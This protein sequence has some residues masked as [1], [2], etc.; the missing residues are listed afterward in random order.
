MKKKYVSCLV[1][2]V[3]V[4]IGIVMALPLGALAQKKNMSRTEDFIVVSGQELS[5]LF[6]AKIESLHL[7]QCL[8][9]SCRPMP[10]QVDKV[11]VLGR[12]VFP[13]DKNANRD[14]AALDDNDE[15]SFMVEDAGDRIPDG[16]RPPG[17]KRGVE[18]EISD[19]LDGGKAWAYLFEENGPQDSGL[20]DYVSYHT[21]GDLTVIESDQM[22]LGF[23][24]GGVSYTLL[25]MISPSGELG[26]SVLDRQRMGAE[27]VWLG[28]VN[29]SMSAPESIMET[30]DIGVIDGPVRV[31]VDEIVLVKMGELSFQWGTEYFFKVYRCG[32][33]N[34]VVY[35]FP[36]AVNALFQSTLLYWGLDF[37]PDMI[38]SSYLD[39]NH[40]QPVLITDTAISDFGGTDENYWYAVYGPQGAVVQSLQLGEN[41]NENFACDCRWIQNPK[42]VV[43]RGDFP[44]RLEIG[45]ECREVEKLPEAS[46]YKAE[47]FILVPRNPDREGVSALVNLIE[48]PLEYKLKPLT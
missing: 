43:K 41:L 47:N 26:P 27:A 33:N 46:K 12:Y 38:G 44:G 2:A 14:G 17:A 25:R 8:N 21:D 18:I 45:F 39:Q 7:Y 22:A 48:H 36:A 9:R 35:E 19:P 37:T 11:D 34:S 32:H 30:N 40:S 3:I 16:W 29:I 42:P 10:V 13:Q 20:P 28:N 23:T 4:L 24:T 31:I 15:V 6:G 5:N 1:N